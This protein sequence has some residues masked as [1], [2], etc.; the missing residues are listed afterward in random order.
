MN[1]K[2]LNLDIFKD[3][4]KEGLAFDERVID[5]EKYFKHYVF[6]GLVDEKINGT[7]RYYSSK[8][9]ECKIEDFTSRGVD[10]DEKLKKK[11][12]KNLIFCFDLESP[13]GP[14]YKV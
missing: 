11:I 7:T 1:N 8:M 10:V 4:N 13:T 5:L 6:A 3:S 9:K 14:L 12:D 2:K